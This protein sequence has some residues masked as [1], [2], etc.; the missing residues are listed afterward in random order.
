MINAQR[1][2]QNT[3]PSITEPVYRDYSFSSS[4]IELEKSVSGVVAMITSNSSNAILA[5]FSLT[6]SEDLNIAVNTHPQ[7]AGSAR[8]YKT[9]GDLKR[10]ESKD[11]NVPA[12]DVLS[13]LS[14]SQVRSEPVDEISKFLLATSMPERPVRA[15]IPVTSS[16]PRD[17][18]VHASH[19]AINGVAVVKSPLGNIGSG[20]FVADSLLLTNYHVV[21]D[22]KF[23][24]IELFD[25]RSAT[26][27]V[28]NLDIDRDLALIRSGVPGQPLEFFSGNVLPLGESVIAIGHPEGLK[29]SITKGII[30]AVR[31]Q[32]STTS[33]GLG[34]RFLF[35]QTD[36]AISPGNSGGPLLL[37]NKVIGI[38]T[39]KLVDVDVE[40]IGFA[41]HY[42]EIARYLA[43]S[44]SN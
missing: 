14:S 44:M 4:K 38:N 39:Q 42:T 43:A 41:L 33:I 17:R 2:L 32:Q 11:F 36:T 15:A 7:D 22:S 26:G 9:A 27:R 19:P 18:M 13:K 21:T 31:E 25:G 37:D 20:F 24:E 3:S 1:R 8:W 28:L 10:E 35:V 12:L 30:S 5:P 16:N 23:V 6:D 34:A 29:F 40:G